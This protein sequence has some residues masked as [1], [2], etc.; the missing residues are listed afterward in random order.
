VPG[1]P[2]L[3]FP[4]PNTVGAALAESLGFRQ[5]RRIPRMR[6]GPPVTG[7]HPERIFN[8]FSFAVG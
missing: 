2:R 3:A 4:E 6:L 8:V 1:E 5:V 7:F